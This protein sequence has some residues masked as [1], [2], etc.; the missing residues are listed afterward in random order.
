MVEVPPSPNHAEQLKSPNMTYT[1][2]RIAKAL[3]EAQGLQYIAADMLGINYRHMSERINKSEYLKEIR[4]FAKEKRLDEAEK[5]LQELVKEKNSTSILFTL[6]T[7]GK[8]RGYEETT[9]IEMPAH[10]ERAMD[11]AMAHF[12]PKGPNADQVVE[13]HEMVHSSEEKKPESKSKSKNKS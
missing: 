1:D 7:I 12:K 10:I 3:L 5:N 6:K 4:S 2:E 9:K 11:E 8:S 13:S